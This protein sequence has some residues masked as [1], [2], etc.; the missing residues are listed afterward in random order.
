MAEAKK[1]RLTNIPQHS[2][3]GYEG[4]R[5]DEVPRDGLP[6]RADPHPPEEENP[7]DAEH[8]GGVRS[9]HDMNRVNDYVNDGNPQPRPKN[10]ER[11][12]L[13]SPGS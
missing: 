9:K 13:I 4:D 5:V 7:Y 6:T 11:S 1:V 2:A 12:R 8:P 10:A 3:G